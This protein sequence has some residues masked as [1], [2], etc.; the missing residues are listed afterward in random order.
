MSDLIRMKN[1]CFFFLKGKCCYMGKIN[2]KVVGICFFGIRF[3]NDFFLFKV[4]IRFKL[5]VLFE[6]IFKVMKL[7]LFLKNFLVCIFLE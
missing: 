5:R 3:F 7:F 4:K 1:D 2:F 6:F